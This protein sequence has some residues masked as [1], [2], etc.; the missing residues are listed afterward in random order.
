[1]TY[2]SP[3]TSRRAA[4]LV[5]LLGILVASGCT[6]PRLMGPHAVSTNV[7][8]DDGRNWGDDPYV[9]KS[10]GLDGDRLT[11]EVSYG[12][13][14]RD[15]AFTLVIDES[16]RES[17]PLQLGAVLAHDANGDTCEAWLTASH[18]FDLSLVKIRHNQT[19]GPGAGK[20]VLQIEG[21]PGEPLVYEFDG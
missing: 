4:S 5:L 18:V 9:A 16:F 11:I 1:M 17:D 6:E 3:L 2:S 8:V 10:A 20:I 7:V 19:Y 21:V 13:G 14:C 12:G 15:H